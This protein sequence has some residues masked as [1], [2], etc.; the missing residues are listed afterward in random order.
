MKW[1]K[2]FP[3][4]AGLY[5]FYGYRYGNV[6]AD[7]EF[8]LVTVTKIS[9]G[10]MVTTNGHWVDESEVEEALF[11]KTEYPEVPKWEG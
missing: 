8:C 2:N 7:K 1:T 9:N 10:F 11:C 6:G 4:K 3:K 5:W